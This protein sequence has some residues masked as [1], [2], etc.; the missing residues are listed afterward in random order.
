MSHQ[1]IKLLI[2]LSF[3]FHFV[4]LQLVPFSDPESLAENEIFYPELE[5]HLDW[6]QANWKLVIP[7]LMERQQLRFCFALAKF[8]E[9]LVP[10][11]ACQAILANG[12]PMA[13]CDIGNIEDLTMTMRY[14]FGGIL[15]DTSRKCRPGL[16]LFG[17][18]CRRMA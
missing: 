3:S 11:T 5:D 15:L 9:R 13:N 14:A 2:L 17:V 1:S 16:V 10:G 8:D 18:R 12:P 4:E 7:W 6:S